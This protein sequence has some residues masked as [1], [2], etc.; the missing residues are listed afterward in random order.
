MGPTTWADEPLNASL[1]TP[2]I[3]HT[4]ANHN[5]KTP[6][7]VEYVNALAKFSGAHTITY[8]R[9]GAEADEEVSAANILIGACLCVPACLPRGLSVCHRD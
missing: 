8:R 3:T 4:H 7:Q 2:I 9:K 5:H 6:K 1:L